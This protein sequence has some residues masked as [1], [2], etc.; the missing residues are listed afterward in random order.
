MLRN[1]L[2]PGLVSGLLVVMLAV[3]GCGKDGGNDL[4]G[5][6]TRGD[7]GGGNG[8]GGGGGGGGGTVNNDPTTNG[9]MPNPDGTT[10]TPIPVDTTIYVPSDTGSAG[11]EGTSTALEFQTS[12]AARYGLGTCGANGTWTAPNGTSYGPHNPNCIL[13]AMDSTVGNNGKGMCVTSDDGDP[14]LWLNP[15]LHPTSPYHS[16]CLRL[17]QSTDALALSFP[18]EAVLYTAN[19]GSGGKILNFVNSGTVV[20][21]LVYDAGRGHHHRLGRVGRARWLRP[22]ALLVHRFRPA[23]AQ[24]HRRPRQWRR[25]LGAEE[26]GRGRDR[27]QHRGGLFAGDA[28]DSVGGSGRC[29]PGQRPRSYN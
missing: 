15:Q 12:G 20:A 26:L 29:L 5:P 24:L 17:G 8:T 21:Q 2:L 3:A 25:H 18:A 7:G 16:N 28:Q 1:R 11:S 22:L 19:D 14:G 4:T 6:G 23:G 13:Y 10:P 27:V 9:V